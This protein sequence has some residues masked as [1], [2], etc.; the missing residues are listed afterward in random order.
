MNIFVTI[1]RFWTRMGSLR[2]IVVAF[3]TYPVEK[4]ATRAEIEAEVEIVGGL[5]DYVK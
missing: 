3:G 2:F 1:S 4:F 5:E